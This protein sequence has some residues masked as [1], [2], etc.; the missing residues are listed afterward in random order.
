L[1][2]GKGQAAGPLPGVL[3]GYYGSAAAMDGG[4]FLIMVAMPFKVLDLGG[5]AL[6]LGLAAAIGAFSYIVSAPAAGHWSDRGNR[7]LLC[8]GG[9]LV[10][11]VCAGAAWLTGRLAVL[12]AL[13][14]L[15]GVGKALYWPAVQATLADLSHTGTRVRVLGRFNVAWSG[16]KTLGFLAGGLL[17]QAQG[18]GAVYLAGAV[19]VAAAFVLLPRGARVAA[20]VAAAAAANDADAAGQAHTATAASPLADSTGTAGPSRLRLF[21]TMGWVANT[22]AFGAFGILTHH[23]P[24]WFLARG[25]DPGHYGWFLGAILA[26]QTAVL[27]VLGGRVRLVWSARRLW[28]PQGLG[29]MAVGLIPLCGALW[30]LLLLAPLIGLACGVSYAASIFYSLEATSG[31]GRYAGIHEGLIGAGGF[32]PPLLAG[33]LVQAG[34]GLAVPYFLAAAL[35]GS[36]L[37]LQM[38]LFL[39][40]ARQG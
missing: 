6:A 11:V 35:L 22:A 30:P 32:L 14:A 29:L 28:L 34:L 9:G 27:S 15:L 4:F 39:R 13:Q 33:L 10:L 31:R 5:G 25:W 26:S 18:F 21:R 8:L 12:L 3:R 16:G 1:N 2:A 23:L 40:Q 37:L 17:L 38:G 20:A 7:T 19:C 36:A 24:Q